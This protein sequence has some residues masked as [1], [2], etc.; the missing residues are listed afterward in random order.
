MN[1]LRL[2]V[3]AAG[4]ALTW[5]IHAQPAKGT[6]N[7]LFLS[8]N[9]VCLDN[10]GSITITTAGAGAFSGKLQIGSTRAAISGTFT[11]GV[12]ERQGIALAKQS[13]NIQLQWDV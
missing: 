7:G 10:S 2:L 12:F 8:T 9:G 6:Y 4:C 1:L 5:S 11:G 13:L 3:L